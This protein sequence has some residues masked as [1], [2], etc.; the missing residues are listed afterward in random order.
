MD[1]QLIT[2]QM[3]HRS[4]MEDYAQQQ[5]SGLTVKAWCQE[6]GI[7]QKTFYY[8][9]RV[10]REEACSLLSTE[11]DKPAAENAPSFVR[12]GMTKAAGDSSGIKIKLD[13]AEIS[14]SPDA[15]NEHVRMVLEAIAHA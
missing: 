15:S 1:T 6:K 12:V 11:Q 3:R 5:E 13:S 10:L 4:W 2:T 9:L 14:I 8:R 7:T